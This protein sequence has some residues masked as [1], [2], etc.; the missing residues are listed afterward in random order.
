MYK[1]GNVSELGIE[2]HWDNNNSAKSL[3][4]PIGV[5]A[6]GEVFSLDLHEAYHA[7]TVLLLVLPVPV[8]VNFCRHLSCHWQSTTVRKKLLSFW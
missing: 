5:M 1:V 2:S 4:A 3:A 8:R 7:V 6:G